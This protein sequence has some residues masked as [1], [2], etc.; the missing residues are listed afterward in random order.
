MGIE[1]GIAAVGLGMSAASAGISFFGSKKQSDAQQQQLLI[2]QQQEALRKQ[3]MKLDATR[4]QREIIRQG[5]RERAYALA[6]TTNQGAGGAG[7]SALPGAYGQVSG[8]QNVNAL[9]V[10]QNLQ[11]GK[12]MFGTNQQMLSAY[13][14]AAVGQ[15]WSQMGSA[16]GSL[17]G[18]I[19]NNAGAIARVGTYAFGSDHPIPIASSTSWFKNV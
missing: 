9:G 15:S 4:R 2:Q 10:A 7:G 14:D 3:Q 5:I 12:K 18:Q 6:A 16:L 8:Q 11:I 1:T 17:G 19:T 13:R